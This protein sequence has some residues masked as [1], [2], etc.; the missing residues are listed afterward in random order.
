MQL[1][2]KWLKYF[3]LIIFHGRLILIST[4]SETRSQSKAPIRKDP[5]P[6][7]IGLVACFKL[8]VWPAPPSAGTLKST[9]C[10]LLDLITPS[11]A[12]VVCL[13][14]LLL[15]SKSL[16]FFFAGE[17]ASNIRCHHALFDCSVCLESEF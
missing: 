17:G 2:N 11:D 1:F 15:F 10:T 3:C 12:D 9:R 13:L 14:I 5:A 8:L 16:V 4:S 6:H 7:L